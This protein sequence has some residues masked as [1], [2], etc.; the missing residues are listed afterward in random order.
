MKHS[1]I[2]LCLLVASLYARSSHASVNLQ[3]CAVTPTSGGLVGCPNASVS[4]T[5]VSSATL[6]RSQV[7]G[8]QGWRPYSTLN[9][10]DMVVAQ[11]DGSWHALGS[12]AVATATSTPPITPVPPTPPVPVTVQW[13][14]MNWVCSTA[15]N[16]VTCTAP[17]SP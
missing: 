3:T 12:L 15:S 17:L 10:A 16:V 5:P 9:P 2:L 11:S 4:Y 7:A 14:A 1:L 6:V 13:Q 8:V